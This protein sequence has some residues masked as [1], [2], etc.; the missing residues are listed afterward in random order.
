MLYICNRI[1]A[2]IFFRMICLIMALKI[3][4]PNK[5]VASWA[6][7]NFISA[8]IVPCCSITNFQIWVKIYAIAFGRVELF[9]SSMWWKFQCGFA[10][11][12]TTELVLYLHISLQIMFPNMYPHIFQSNYPFT[13]FALNGVIMVRGWG[14]TVFTWNKNIIWYNTLFDYL[15]G[16]SSSE[17]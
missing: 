12:T 4:G 6:V 9:V 3:I 1:G 7:L 5:D 14:T 13:D 10:T 11:I 8:R 2:S 15:I 16:I 17:I